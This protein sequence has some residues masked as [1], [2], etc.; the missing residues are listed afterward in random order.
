[1]SLTPGTPFPAPRTISGERRRNLVFDPLRRKKIHVK[2]TEASASDSSSPQGDE[3]TTDMSALPDNFCIIESREAVKNFANMQLDELENNIQSRRNKIFLLME[4]V[5]RL[6]IQQRLRQDAPGTLASER[7][8]TAQESYPSFIPFFPPVNED[9]L[10]LYT[11][12]YFLSVA[13]IILFGAL[14]APSLEVRLGLGGTSYHDFIASVHL[15]QQL[16]EVDPIV[17]SFCGGAVGVLTSLLIVETNNS[18]MQAKQK[19]IYCKGAGYLP[20]GNCMGSGIATGDDST[21]ATAS[22]CSFCS[23]SGK[24]MCTACLCTGKQLATEHDPRVDPF[25]LS[26]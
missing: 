9:T 15:P 3:T 11:N 14:I 12:F 19:C 7:E 20:C 1:M 18:K 25:T 13:A 6:R 16:A 26:D 23:G 2:S 24:V 5:R 22:T 10:R 21:N 17:A 8:E 4:E